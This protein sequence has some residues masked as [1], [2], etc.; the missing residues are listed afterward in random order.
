MFGMSKPNRD[1]HLVND[2]LTKLQSLHTI[3]LLSSRSEGSLYVRTS[4]LARCYTKQK[5]PMTMHFCGTLHFSF[6]WETCDSNWV[7]LE[8]DEDCKENDP[9]SLFA[10]LVIERQQSLGRTRL[11]RCISVGVLR[12]NDD[13]EA[14]QLIE[15]FWYP[16]D[17]KELWTSK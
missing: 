2:S 13:L 14:I 5:P 8:Y 7:S 1:L 16:N 4:T 3:I 17:N 12:P 15:K 6:L 11:S 10:I 9:R